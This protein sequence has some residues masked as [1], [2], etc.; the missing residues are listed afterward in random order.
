[1][2]LCIQRFKIACSICYYCF[3]YYKVCNP[4]QNFVNKF[5][6]EQLILKFIWKNKSAEITNRILQDPLGWVLIY[7]MSTICCGFF[8]F[9][10]VIL[11]LELKVSHLSVRCFTTW[12]T[13]PAKMSKNNMMGEE[14]EWWREQIQL[15]YILNVYVNITVYSPVQLLYAN[16]IIKN[17][18]MARRQVVHV[19]HACK[20]SY[21][22][23]RDQED[24]CLKPAHANSLLDP[25]S[26]IPNTSPNFCH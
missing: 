12:A 6:W 8:F 2:S 15:R 5:T 24:L 22:K 11:G 21:S 18:N 19:A 7:Q 25:I 13:P 9:F 3:F 10:F 17:F 23:G 20:P 16:K 26:K 14:G 1:L 4:P